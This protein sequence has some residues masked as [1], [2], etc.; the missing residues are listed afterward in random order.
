M[1]I[2]TCP[3]AYCRLSVRLDYDYDSRYSSTTLLLTEALTIGGLV[4]AVP[5]PAIG[6]RD[7]GS[8]FCS[9]QTCD[10]TKNQ[11]PRSAGSDDKIECQ[12][13]RSTGSHDKIT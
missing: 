5:V 6:A 10:A 2:H 7:S 8:G 13:Q 3:A 1:L 4:V 12:D 9:Q 11:D